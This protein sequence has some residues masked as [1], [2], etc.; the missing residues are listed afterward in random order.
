M[1][2]CEVLKDTFI[3]VGKGSI[4]FVNEKQYE[5]A[6]E[7][8]KPITEKV[9]ETTNEEVVEEAPKKKTTKKK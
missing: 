5:L 3:S 2:K 1:K 4:V 6:R 7:V 8:L 9:V